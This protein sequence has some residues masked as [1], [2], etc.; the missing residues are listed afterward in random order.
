MKKK[1]EQ[2]LQEIEKQENIEILY[3][4]ES[5][6]R[7]WGFPSKDSDY[8]V[9]FIYRRKIEWYL[10]L[11]KRADHLEFPID[12]QLDICGWDLDKTLKLL[13]KSN[14]V[15]LE[16]LNSPIVYSINTQ[17]LTE[18]RKLSEENLNEQRLI[19]HYLHMADG[20]YR[21]YLKKEHVRI[22][23]Y[24]YVLRPILACMWIKEYHQRPP[25][26]FE[27]LL[28]LP[29]L[30]SELLKVINELL[31]RKRLGDELAIE[32]AIPLLNAFL[33]QQLQFF[34][35]YVNLLDKSPKIPSTDLN[36]FFLRWIK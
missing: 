11:D 33:D 35:E 17:F 7:A 5:G 20:N 29:N 27:K 10:K 26:E 12:K 19:Y 1:I 34:T 22:K 6:S 24:F 36:S 18:L 13:Q 30:S 16:W 31:I 21:E 4:I 9:R 15:L 28:E 2:A 3:A 32:M 23:K 25:V 14:P 8:D